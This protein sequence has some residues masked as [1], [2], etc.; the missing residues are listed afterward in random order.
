MQQAILR[1]FARSYMLPALLLFATVAEAQPVQVIVNV[2]PPHSSFAKDY[3]QQG[4][5]VLITVINNAPSPQSVRLIPSLT[6]LDN[7]VKIALR[8]N[9]IP[10]APLTLGSGQTRVLTLNQ[11]KAFNNNI[12]PD[13]IIT[14]GISPATYFNGG[15][16]PEGLYRLCVKVHVY[17]NPTGG[18]LFSEGCGMFNI[19]SFDSPI[20]LNPTNNTAVKPLQPQS[21]NFSW[22]P[23]GTVGKTRYSFKLI[24]LTATGIFNANDAFLN[25]YVLPYFE[26]KNILSTSMQMDNSKPKLKVG[27]KYA[28]Q[29][30]AADP[31]NKT[32]YK[33]QGRSQVIVFTYSDPL[34]ETNPVLIGSG[35]NHNDP[36][37]GSC[38]ATSKYDGPLQHSNKNGIA[39]GTNILVGKFVMKQTKFTRTNGSYDGSGEIMVNFLNTKVKVNFSGIQI[40]DDNRMIQGKITAAYAA[41]AGIDETVANDKSGS[42]TTLPNHSVFINMLGETE[43][44]VDLQKT[45]V[46][47]DLPL[48]I[49]KNDFS[50]GLVG[51]IFEPREAFVNAVLS[52]PL[53]GIDGSDHLLLSA[54]GVAFHPYGYGNDAALK[55]LLQQSQTFSI[56]Q[57]LLLELKGGVDHTFARFDCNGFINLSLDAA[58]VLPRNVALPHTKKLQLIDDEKVNVKLPFNLKEARSFN[59]LILD[60]LSFSHPFSIA[61]AADFVFS[62]DSVSLDFSLSGKINGINNADKNISNNWMGVFIKA[63]KNATPAGYGTGGEKP[64]LAELTTIFITKEGIKTQ[65]NMDFKSGMKANMPAPTVED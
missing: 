65:L 1:C 6:G 38:D 17:N 50:I 23:S 41:N 60:G 13:D 8:D 10:S 53:P 9:F 49:D 47:S 22:T 51:M 26:Q 24:D 35:H 30:I 62:A 7:N 27:N 14:Q 33:N 59:E 11:L 63:A 52:T 5:N 25:G 54:K 40:S 36:A 18:S 37:K 29:V 45:A 19:L 57:N 46:A 55:L 32:T 16:L 42:I 39:N 2:T 15:S 64:G 43:R 21:V 28:L 31:Q 58:V 61:D 48:S 3:L 34:L 44:K 4:T 20:I 12:V 56:S